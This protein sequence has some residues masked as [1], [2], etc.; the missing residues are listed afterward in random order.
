MDFVSS[1]QFR[2]NWDGDAVCVCD[3]LNTVVIIVWL[4][5]MVNI[6]LALD[7]VLV[8]NILNSEYDLI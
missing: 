4:I 5:D 3:I 2:V 6:C 8:C 7:V 1:L